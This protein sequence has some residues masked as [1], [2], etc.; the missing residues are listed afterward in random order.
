MTCDERGILPPGRFLTQPER[1]SSSALSF[2][3]DLK[4]TPELSPK[5]EYEP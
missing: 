3:L 4:K 2:V 1:P 5:Q